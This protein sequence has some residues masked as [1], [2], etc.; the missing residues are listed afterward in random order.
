LRKYL[1]KSNVNDNVLAALS[2]ID[3]VWRG[4]AES[5][6]RQQLILMGMWMIWTR[7]HF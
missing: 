4:S 3:E 5:E 1:T 6:S 2:S 7:L